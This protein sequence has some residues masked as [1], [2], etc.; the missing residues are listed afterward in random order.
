[1]R[2]DA[3]C[4]GSSA[5]RVYLAVVWVWVWPRIFPTM[6]R[7]SPPITA[8]EATIRCR[9]A[10]RLRRPWRTAAG[11]LCCRSGTGTG[12]PV[13]E[14][15]P[16]EH[17]RAHRPARRLGRAGRHG[18]SRPDG[19]GAASRLAAAGDAGPAAGETAFSP[20]SRVRAA[21]LSDRPGAA[22]LGGGLGAGARPAR[23]GL[24]RPRTPP[25][26]G[27]V[28]GTVAGARTVERQNCVATPLPI[29]SPDA[30]REPPPFRPLKWTD[31]SPGWNTSDAFMKTSE[32]S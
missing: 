31:G 12:L 25:D 11:R 30:N 14:R 10:G 26:V 3:P 24:A 21:A 19:V 7:L 32:G 20:A 5:R 1:M 23:R 13:A 15:V 4:R 2:S 9:P 18:R 22:P 28:T 8:S 27:R 16:R 29:A 17:A 6:G